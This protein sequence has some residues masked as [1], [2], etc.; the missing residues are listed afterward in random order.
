MPTWLFILLALGEL[1]I[2]VF[3]WIGFKKVRD[4]F[5]RGAEISILGG[6]PPFF[7]YDISVAAEQQEK[8][9]PVKA[10]PRP[11]PRQYKHLTLHVDNGP[12]PASRKLPSN[13]NLRAI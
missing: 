2:L 4:D 12:I 1:I 11:L 13:K 10:R 8:H 9:R 3:A 7:G 5:T 6:E